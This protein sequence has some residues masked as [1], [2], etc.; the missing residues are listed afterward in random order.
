MNTPLLRTYKDKDGRTQVTL[1]KSEREEDALC[2]FCSGQ[3]RP[4]KTFQ[5]A[6]HVIAD[7]NTIST[8]GWAACPPCAKMI[9]AHDRDALLQRSLEAFADASIPEWFQ[10]K[11]LKE[12]HDDFFLRMQSDN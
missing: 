7:I 9:E 10:R 5:C 8:G 4:F 3:E 11:M 2:D 1:A 6:D 12:I